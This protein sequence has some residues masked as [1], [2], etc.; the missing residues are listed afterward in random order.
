MFVVRHTLGA[1]IYMKTPIWREH[2]G[3]VVKRVVPAVLLRRLRNES[4]KR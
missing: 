4:F 1:W 2:L 3:Y